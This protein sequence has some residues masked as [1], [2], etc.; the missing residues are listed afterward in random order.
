MQM[1]KMQ[2]LNLIQIMFICFQK[3]VLKKNLNLDRKDRIAKKIIDS[4]I[5]ND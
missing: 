5:K 4:I 1:R 2:V 3:M